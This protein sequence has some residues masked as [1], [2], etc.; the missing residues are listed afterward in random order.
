MNQTVGTKLRKLREVK[1]LSQHELARRLGYATNSYISNVEKGIFVPPEDK[2][3]KIA[4]A[5][6]VPFEWIK[7][8]LLEAKI[9]GL[10]IKEPA[11]ISLFKDYPH[12]SRQD[13]REIIRAYLK[14]KAASGQH[15]A[16]HHSTGEKSVGG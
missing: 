8:V 14:V 6:E 5:L 10:G 4:Q 3:E 15:D 12:L 11:F 13:R 7:E 9:E 2:L 1:G 16:A